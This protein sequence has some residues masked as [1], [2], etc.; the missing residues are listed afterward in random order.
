ML[1]MAER[2]PTAL[3]IS[4]SAFVA[5]AAGALFSCN[6][7]KPLPKFNQVSSFA[8]LNQ[9]GK[10]VTTDTLQGKV[11]IANF[12]FTRCAGPCP[13]LTAKMKRIQKRTESWKDVSIVSFT[14]DPEHDRPEVL[15]D[16][17][18]KFQVDESRWLFLT[19][20]R[21][22]LHQ[23][24]RF[25]FQLNDV[26]GSMEHA[27]QFALVDKQAVIRG[28]YLSEVEDQLDQ[29]YRDMEQLREEA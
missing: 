5:A 21:E 26:D 27:S 10:L 20:S 25:S 18:R 16:Y 8:L 9:D 6:R 3:P 2:R 23:V 13:R 11:W 15:K 22:A 19:G 14:V 17:A 28:Y 7:A 24:G 1:S 4:R 29:L 12:I